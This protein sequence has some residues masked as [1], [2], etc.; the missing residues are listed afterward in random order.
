MPCGKY[1][2]VMRD[3]WLPLL[4]KAGDLNKPALRSVHG[5][6]EGWAC[7]LFGVGRFDAAKYSSQF[8]GARSVWWCGGVARTFP[9]DRRPR[10]TC[11][12]RTETN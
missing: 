3:L 1:L 2:V 11:V 8:G 4:A 12:K 9:A 10:Q 7:Q 5:N 6:A